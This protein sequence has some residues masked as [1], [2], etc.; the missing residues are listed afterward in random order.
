[1]H[2][3]VVDVARGDL[4]AGGGRAA[5]VAGVGRDKVLGEV[6]QDGREAVVF[7]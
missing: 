5:A 6:V 7:V 3:E 1:V 2:R 4:G